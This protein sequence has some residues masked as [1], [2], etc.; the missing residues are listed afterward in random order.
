VYE[1]QKKHNE[2]IFQFSEAKKL[3]PSQ[4]DAYYL[5]GRIYM[6]AGR[7][8]E[9]EKEFATTKTLHSKAEET[10]IHKVSGDAPTLQP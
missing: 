7:K 3:D 4:A 8:E 1:Q 6:A 5:L 10:L 9:A 2:V